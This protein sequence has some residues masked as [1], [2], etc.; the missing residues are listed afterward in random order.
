MENNESVQIKEEEIKAWK[1][2]E[3]REATE[4]HMTKEEGVQKSKAKLEDLEALE[5]RKLR[6]KALS[7]ARSVL[8][9]PHGFLR[10]LQNIGDDFVAATEE[11][12]S[13]KRISKIFDMYAVAYIRFVESKQTALDYIATYPTIAEA[14]GA[15]LDV[16]DIPQPRDEQGRFNIMTSEGLV[17]GEAKS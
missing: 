15:N 10:A 6:K 14:S 11:R 8:K 9:K 12:L 3:V 13:E 16:P 5:G 1:D 17:S 2:V 4:K 7:K